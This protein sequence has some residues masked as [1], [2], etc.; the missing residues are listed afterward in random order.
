LL[1]SQNES[2]L[3][4]SDSVLDEIS[5]LGPVSVGFL[6]LGRSLTSSDSKVELENVDSSIIE[7]DSNDPGEEDAKTPNP[8]KRVD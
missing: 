4:F 5:K 2:E 1:P 8:F 6:A 3:T 7:F